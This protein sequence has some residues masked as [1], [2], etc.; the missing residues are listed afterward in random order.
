MKWN[1]LE[2]DEVASTNTLASEMLARG[3]AKHGDV[4]Q[5]RHQTSGRGR[6]AGR[7]WNDEPGNSL[8]ISVVLTKIPQ[9]AHLL[10]Y[11]AAL[12]VLRAIREISQE[13]DPEDIQLKWPNDILIHGKKL[14]GLLVEAQWNGPAMRSA[15]IGIGVNVR[16]LSFPLELSGIA[17][18]LHQSGVAATVRDVRDRVLDALKGEFQN[19]SDESIVL[20][21]LRSELAWMSQL[22][23]LDFISGNGETISGLRLEG[24]DDSGALLLRHQ[25]G[26]VETRLTG[27]LSW[28]N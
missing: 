23:P 26:Q 19:H 15:I 3:E 17:T 20:T 9:P 24:L 8:L 28:N 7:V 12:G 18:S 11:R 1:I 27:S 25:N 2:F 5:A 4:I 10:Q 22:F 6:G 21:R 13:L 16:Q 14:S